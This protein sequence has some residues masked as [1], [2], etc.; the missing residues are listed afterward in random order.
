MPVA[1]LVAVIVSRLDLALP[2]VGVATT[3]SRVCDHF[4]HFEQTHSAPRSADGPAVDPVTLPE[5]DEVSVLTLVSVPP[6]VGSRYQL[7]AA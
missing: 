2:G 7:S 6:S 5:V 3:V 4:D 1:S